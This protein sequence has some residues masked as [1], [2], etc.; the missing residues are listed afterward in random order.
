M[1]DRLA[2][3]GQLLPDQPA[4][5]VE[6]AVLDPRFDDLARQVW[7]PRWS[8]PE[9]ASVPQ[10]V[11]QYPAVNIAVEPEDAALYLP[12]DGVGTRELVG[13]SW[14]AGLL[15][16]PGA[17]G[18]VVPGDHSTML[19][20]RRTIPRSDDLVARL[21]ATMHDAPITEAVAAYERWLERWLDDVDDETRLVNAITDAAEQDPEV[22]APRDLVERFGVP[23]RTLQRLMRR[24]VGFS[25]RW[26]IQRRRLQEAAF[27][28][29]EETDTGLADV[30]ADL[31]YADQAHFTRD[32]RSVIGTTPGEYRRS[33]AVS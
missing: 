20:A 25:P 27:R 18:L 28:L 24:R 19:G 7:V 10:P 12:A 2:T 30:A 22:T 31:G 21:R 23:E 17:G 33:T 16:R 32:F 26:L 4:A 1:T 14:A 9:G 8:V 29:R 11:L 3:K 5:S 15:L 13:T 6:R